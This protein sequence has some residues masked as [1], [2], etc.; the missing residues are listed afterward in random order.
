M[1]RSPS[2]WSPS[3]SK[4]CALLTA[5]AGVASTVDAAA[6]DG[7]GKVRDRR[8]RFEVARG[9]RGGSAVNLPLAAENFSFPANNVQLMAWLPLRDFGFDQDNA[10]ACF[11]YVAPSGREYA[12]I[13][14][15]GGTAFVEIT[16]PGD[17]AIVGYV[18]GPTSLWRDMKVYGSTC[19]AVSE[20]GF[21]IQV[22][23]MAQIDA[24]VV[25]LAGSVTTGGALSTHTVAVDADSGFL[26]RC[27]GSGNGL[28]I[29]DLANPL[30]PAYVADWNSRYVHESQ[31]VTYT[32]GPYAGKQI[33]FAC[34]GLNGGFDD[35]SLDIIDVTNKSNIVLMK[36]FRYSGRSYSHQG[37]LSAD[38]QWFYLNDELDETGGNVMRTRVI[39]VA[40]LT[41]PVEHP[42]FTTGSTAIDHNLYVHDGKIYESNYRSGLHVLDAS[43]PATPVQIASFDT[44]PEN[45][46]AN[47]NSLWDNYPFLPSGTIVGS[48]IEKGL[49][50]WRIGAPD[51]EF[52]F[53]AGTP[54]L[55]GPEGEAVALE[56]LEAQPGMLSP[57]TVRLH[58][59][60]GGAWTDAPIAV[61]PAGD[62]LASFPPTSCG[63]DIAWYVTARDAHGR[64][65]SWPQGAP[66][67]VA[68]ATAVSGIT[69]LATDSLE[70]VGGW[71][72]AQAT[73]TATG[74]RWVF[75]DPVGTVAQ[76]EDDHTL[77]GIQCW[78]TGQAQP[79]YQSGTADVDGG[80]TTLT[81]PDYD[82]SGAVD[83]IISYWRWYS[84]A[85][86]GGT[87]YED[88]FAI[89][90]SNDGG[91]SWTPVEVVGPAGDEVRGGWFLHQFRVAQLLPPTSQV[92]MRFVAADLGNPSTIEAAIDDFA[93]ADVTCAPLGPT[94]YCVAKM[95]SQGCLPAIGT[96]G[97][98]STSSPG[99]FT[100]TCTNVLSNKAGILVYGSQRAAI[101]FQGATLCIASPVR[102]TPIQQSGGNP[103]PVDCSGSFGFDFNAH[104]AAGSDPALVPG[105]RVVAQYWSRD[106]LDPTGFGSSLSDACE[107]TI[108]P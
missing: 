82:L 22:I 31:A 39:N 32:S 5:L 78:F 73:D 41:D 43:V 70:T 75:G 58:V 83:P 9:T 15:Y 51:L 76:P 67:L 100:V 13:G 108:Q 33:V 48:D 35:T 19:Y 62:Y 36:R 99:P 42:F 45:E 101:P 28:R 105:R 107:F 87:P 1:R 38:K 88:V 96:S 12:I 30:V 26:Y 93:I 86:A 24:G 52:A 10:N 59:N 60:S 47:F 80:H 92:R 81:T 95:N 7:D 89:D 57:G 98:P 49:F 55:V 79:H 54:T 25:A 85:I 21:G 104:I 68:H 6:H 91:A 53:P 64:T 50:L 103:P 37:W 27:G 102:R 3:G 97:T 17:P 8:P 16:D 23:D 11:G 90:I 94:T 46:A 44:Y 61:Q 18:A 4:A 29:Y 66:T 74:G 71:V 40:S 72:G 69:Y 34:G 77:S 56:I 84:N 14:L 65:W 63:A 2:L 20:G 106:S